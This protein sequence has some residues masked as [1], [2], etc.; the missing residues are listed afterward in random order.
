MFNQP[1]YQATL[2]QG[3][4]RGTGTVKSAQNGI[5]NTYNMG[6]NGLVV[7]NHRAVWAGDGD[8]TIKVCSLG[9]QLLA[10][11]STAGKARVGKGCFDPVHQTVLFVND[12][13][14]NFDTQ[15]PTQSVYPF[16]TIFNAKT[17]AP[18]PGAKQTLNPAYMDPKTPATTFAYIANYY[19]A[20]LP[21]GTA[22]HTAASA[23]VGGAFMRPR[24]SPSGLPSRNVGTRRRSNLTSTKSPS[25]RLS[26]LPDLYSAP[27]LRPAQIRTRVMVA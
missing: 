13:E 25:R 8:S 20:P 9:G 2:C 1:H 12:L 10:T 24:P 7:V 22:L 3:K 15:N 5:N 6:P 21:V 23:G 27:T 16:F 18:M 4:F 14:R 19:P 11:I 26:A 17:Y